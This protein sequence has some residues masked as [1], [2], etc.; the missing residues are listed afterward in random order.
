MNNPILEIENLR[1]EFPLSRKRTLVAIRESSLHVKEGEVVG[2]VGESGCGKSMTAYSILQIVPPPGQIISGKILFNKKNLLEKQEDSL[3]LLRGKEI[4]LI[5]QDPLS[6]LNPVY[7]IFW[8]FDEVYRAHGISLTKKQKETQII[9]QLKIVGIPEP[10]KRLRHYPHQFSGGMRQRVIIALALLLKP[11]L[12]IADEPTTAL[13][14]TTQRAIFELLKTLRSSLNLSLIVIS[15]DLYLIA[16]QCDR[17]YV[18]Y[19]G[20]IMESGNAESVFNAPLHPYSIG[21]MKS[22]PSL[23]YHVDKLEVIRGEFTKVFEKDITGCCF[24]N[25][26]TLADE[27]CFRVHPLIKEVKTGRFVRCL[28][29]T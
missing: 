12:I 17:M 3:R 26:C 19:G 15:H 18:M 5:C 1:V 24:A 6:S 8:H 2:I 9:E 20:E 29:V 7:T 11:Q 4:S 13:D 10:E 16:E 28:K 22:I 27:E 14:V 25:R 23:D 21:L